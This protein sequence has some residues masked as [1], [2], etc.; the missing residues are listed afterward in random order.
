MFL[1]LIWKYESHVLLYCHNTVCKVKEFCLFE[2]WVTWLTLIKKKKKIFL[3]RKFR[4]EQLQSHIH[5]RKVFL[6]Y[7]EMCKYLTI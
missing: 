6:I 1:V 7:E 3:I 4:I 2:S 5:M